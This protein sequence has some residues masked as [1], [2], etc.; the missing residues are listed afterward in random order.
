[1]IFLIKKHFSLKKIFYKQQYFMKNQL[2][3]IALTTN[4]KPPNEQIPK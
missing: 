4:N 1:M 3:I 2:K